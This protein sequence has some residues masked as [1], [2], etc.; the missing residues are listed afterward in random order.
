MEV[1]NYKRAINFSLSAST[2]LD[3]MAVLSC[4]AAVHIRK[5][6]RMK[7]RQINMRTNRLSVPSFLNH[8]ILLKERPCHLQSGSAFLVLLGLTC[9]T[10]PARMIRRT[11][12]KILYSTVILHFGIAA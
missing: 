10:E 3:F 2:D 9:Q 7:K 12:A 8:G 4:Y 1:P 5:T 6:Q 11:V